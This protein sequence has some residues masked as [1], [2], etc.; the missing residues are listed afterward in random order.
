MTV[1][2]DDIEW[3]IEFAS[4]GCGDSE[5]YLDTESGA[6]YYIGDAVEEPIP[7]DLYDSDKYLQ[8]PDKRELDL[9]KHLVI[10]FTS[11]KIP[12]HL[13]TVYDMFRKQGA[14]SRLKDLLGSLELLDAWYTY[15]ELALKQA[16]IDWC[17][18]NNINFSSDI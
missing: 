3:A 13:D 8:I 17:K 14:Y 1:K 18:A 10:R 11:E 15:E 7:D 6:I 4:S 16:T 9:G 2:L 12:E 5:A